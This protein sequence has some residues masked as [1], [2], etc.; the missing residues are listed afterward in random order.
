MASDVK[1]KGSL[2][3]SDYEMLEVRILR[4]WNKDNSKVTTLD[5]RRGNLGLFRVGL[6][7]EQASG[8]AG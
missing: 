2:G 4:E 1:V 8:R 6:G 7:S 3:C 5:I